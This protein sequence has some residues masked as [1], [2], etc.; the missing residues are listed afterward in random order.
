MPEVSSSTASTVVLELQP[1]QAE[2]LA[3]VLYAYDALHDSVGASY[4]A[5]Q[6]VEDYDADEWNPV[7]LALLGEAATVCVPFLTAAPG[8]RL[9]EGS[10]R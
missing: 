9:V 7:A 10:G 1:D 6:I 5:H 2:T 3:R 4:H 8:L